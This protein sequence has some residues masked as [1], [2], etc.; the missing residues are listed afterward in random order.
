MGDHKI[1]Y[2]RVE[3]PELKP[4]E[5]KV[6]PLP[7]SAVDPSASAEIEEWETKREEW[8]GIDVTVYDGKFSEVRW[9][10]EGHVITIWSNVNFM[11]FSS[12]ADFET[13]DAIYGMMVTGWDV[14]TKEA[15]AQ[16]A[17]ATTPAEIMPFPPRSLRT[18]AKV[19][20]Q[21]Q[22]VGVISREATEVMNDLHAYYRKHGTKMAREYEQRIAE[23]EAREAW[24]KKHP[25]KPQDTIINFFPIRST[26]FKTATT[27]AGKTGK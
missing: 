6:E 27:K 11:H 4:E 9:Y 20:P 10:A 19:G 26:F 8:L 17:Q 24:E 3:P 5:P 18:L 13:P 7:P 21:W 1:I 22:P 2:N 15:E 25:T 16:N 23:A 14:T 12:M